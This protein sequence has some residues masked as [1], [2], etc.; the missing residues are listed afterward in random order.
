M[1]QVLAFSLLMCSLVFSLACQAAEWNNDPEALVRSFQRENAKFNEMAYP[2]ADLTNENPKVMA[3]WN[4]IR[5]RYFV[6]GFQ[7]VPTIYISQTVNRKLEEKIELKSANESTAVVMV[8]ERIRNT[9]QNMEGTNVLE[10]HMT[11]QAGR[12]YIENVYVHYRGGKS[13]LY[14]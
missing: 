14:Q 1:K 9:I 8:T 3:A 11:W 13:E 6:P 7:G 2:I 4:K 5:K 10:Y 12:W